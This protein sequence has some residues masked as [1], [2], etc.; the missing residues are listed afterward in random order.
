MT[1]DSPRRPVRTGR[2]MLV[3]ELERDVYYPPKFLRLTISRP[4]T[5]GAMTR[6]FSTAGERV[7]TRDIEQVIGWISSSLSNALSSTEGIQTVIDLDDP[8]ES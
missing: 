4:G 7:T 6:V 1:Q 3:I 8:P 2:V 5:Q